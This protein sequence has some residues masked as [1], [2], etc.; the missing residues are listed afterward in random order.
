MNQ[1]FA[2]QNQ[3]VFVCGSMDPLLTPKHYSLQLPSYVQFTS[4]I[5]RFMDLVVH[6]L[7]KAAL[8]NTESP[9]S[10]REI[11]SILKRL[12][13][14]ETKRYSKACALLKT[15]Y[16]LRKPMYLPCF[17]Q[18][19]DANGFTFKSPHLRGLSLRGRTV[20]YSNLSVSDKPDN[21]AKSKVSQLQ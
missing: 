20:K 15:T 14:L 6:R 3:A 19:F 10:E 12:S 5:R 18:D 2:I 17:V 4:P 11:S 1:W 7:V 9:Y 8:D 13:G 21:E 16:R